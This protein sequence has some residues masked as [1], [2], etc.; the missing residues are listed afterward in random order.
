[1]HHRPRRDQGVHGPELDIFIQIQSSHK[2]IPRQSLVPKPDRGASKLFKNADDAVADLQSGSILW[3]SGFRLCGIA[4]RVEN[5]VD[6]QHFVLAKILETIIDAIHRRGVESLGSLTAVSN[7]TGASGD[8]GVSVLTRTGQVTRLIL[9]YLA[10]N[11]ILESKFLSG[12]IA[13]ELCPQGSLAEKLRAGAAEVPAVYTPTG[14][15][16]C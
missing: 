7:N 4:G 14:V 3:S 8:H 12:N 9:S 1:M 16:R 5:P 13:I 15:P 10:N 11:K 6:L 2:A